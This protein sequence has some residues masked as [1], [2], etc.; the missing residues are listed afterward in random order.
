M[1]P[2]VCAR[3]SMSLNLV[4]CSPEYYRRYPEE[5]EFLT[6]C[7]KK[8]PRDVISALLGE[9][10]LDPDAINFASIMTTSIKKVSEYQRNEKKRRL[11]T[12]RRGCLA[13]TRLNNKSRWRTQ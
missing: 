5:L 13:R 6:R 4:A 8:F 9:R 11:E 7:M 12:W 2:H 1:F 10:V 3:D